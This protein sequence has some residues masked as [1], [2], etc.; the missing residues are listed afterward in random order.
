MLLHGSPA[1]VVSISIEGVTFI[2]MI[3]KQVEKKKRPGTWIFY[4][5]ARRCLGNVAFLTK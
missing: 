2:I 1:A 5:A 3:G 4:R